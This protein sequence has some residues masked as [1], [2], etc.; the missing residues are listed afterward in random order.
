M[1]RVPLTV[2]LLSQ[3]HHEILCQTIF[4]LSRGRRGTQ[5]CFKFR[6]VS[7]PLLACINFRFL[8][9][10]LLL[11]RANATRY[12]HHA[13]VQLGRSGPNPPRDI[14]LRGLSAFPY[15]YVPK[16]SC[17]QVTA[18][19]PSPTANA[20]RLVVPERQSPAAKIPGHDVSSTRGTRF[21]SGHVAL[22]ISSAPVIRKPCLSLLIL[23]PRKS[24][25]GAAPIK[26]NT[27]QLSS[28]VVSDVATFSIDT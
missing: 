6:F 24:V 27:A 9:S 14:W 3:P 15:A 8:S 28:T 19:A 20:T 2:Q 4:A 12:P 25:Q 26:M 22:A 17:T 1:E 13:G 10:P 16:R 5:T 23:S 21:G 11:L 7:S 18:R